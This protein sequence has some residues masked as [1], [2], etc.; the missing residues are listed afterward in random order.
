MSHVVPGSHTIAGYN[1][2]FDLPRLRR[3]SRSLAASPPQLLQPKRAA[4]ADAP[5]THA[6]DPAPGSAPTE[7][8]PIASPVP[9]TTQGTLPF[10]VLFKLLANSVITDLTFLYIIINNTT[11][12]FFTPT[13]SLADDDVEEG[14]TAGTSG[15]GSS[16]DDYAMEL[17]IG[18]AS[19]LASAAMIGFS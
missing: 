4:T 15:D 9:A 18:V 3:S 11:R 10:T 7:T 14:D 6:V 1:E 13:L 19:T 5:S 8:E 12:G 17:I 2:V 16:G